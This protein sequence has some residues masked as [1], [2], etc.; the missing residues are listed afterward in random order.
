V[1]CHDCPPVRAR[2]SGGPR[3]LPQAP[4]VPVARH[5]RRLQLRARGLASPSGSCKSRRTLPFRAMR[6][7]GEVVAS[8]LLCAGATVSRPVGVSCS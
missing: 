3:P 4:I 6:S 7:R 5:G 8:Q 2:R 1:M